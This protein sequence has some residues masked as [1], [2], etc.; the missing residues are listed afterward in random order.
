MLINEYL[1]LRNVSAAAGT[2]P[3]QTAKTDA[4]VKKPQDSAFAD[5]LREKLVADERKQVEFSRH[6]L[7]R[8]SQRDIS[9]EEDN[10]LERLNKAVEIAE[11]K[12]S[13]DTLIILDSTAF[14]VSVKNNRV[15]T[16]MNAEDM[17]GNIITNI[18]STVIM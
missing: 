16:T 2:A 4:S 15:I 14:L 12:G 10:M 3:A 17:Q 6:A 7:D 5:A 18:D 1:Q 9:L 8:I 11:Q 13:N